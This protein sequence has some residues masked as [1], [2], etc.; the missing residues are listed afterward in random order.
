MLSFPLHAIITLPVNS[1][2]FSALGRNKLSESVRAESFMFS[3]PSAPSKIG[4]RAGFTLVE[5]LVV[6]GVIGILISLLLPAVQSVRARAGQSQCASNLRQIGLALNQFLD[7]LGPNTTFPDAAMLPMTARGR[8]A[9][10]R[11][12]ETV[13]GGGQAAA[14]PFPGPVHGE[15]PGGVADRVR[16]Y[17]V[18]IPVHQPRLCRPRY[19]VV[20]AISSIASSSKGSAIK[21]SRQ[22]L[23]A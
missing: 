5:L 1:L 20:R 21:S 14:V 18:A 9:G 6:I 16:Q 8:S 15:R 4:P 3:A 12:R 23:P 19:G 22:R 11:I 13:R 7:A 2:L 17:G 10:G